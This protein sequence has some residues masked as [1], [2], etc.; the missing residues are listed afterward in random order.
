[1]SRLSRLSNRTQA[2]SM[3]ALVL[4]NGGRGP[5]RPLSGMSERGAGIVGQENQFPSH[6]GNA[7]AFPENYA[8]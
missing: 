1:M 4:L 7:L 2:L 8:R 3:F 6:D 5:E